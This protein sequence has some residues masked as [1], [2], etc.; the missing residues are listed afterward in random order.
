MFMPACFAFSSKACDVGEGTCFVLYFQTILHS[1][2]P[3]V[4][5]IFDA[6]VGIFESTREKSCMIQS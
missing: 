1:V 2:G 6:G 4:L 3:R 5:H